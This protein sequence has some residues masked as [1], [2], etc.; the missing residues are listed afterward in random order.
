MLDS[1]LHLQ[2][3]SALHVVTQPGPQYSGPDLK[4]FLQGLTEAE[5]AV[6]TDA[7]T[8]RLLYHPDYVSQMLWNTCSVYLL[9]AVSAPTRVCYTTLC[10]V[11]L[12]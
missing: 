3:G 11:A 7:Y 4:R 5:Q 10:A 2:A 8:Q 1:L 9:A 12:G 6:V